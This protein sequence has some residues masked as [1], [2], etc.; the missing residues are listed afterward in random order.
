[1]FLVS[2]I[3]WLMLFNW[4]FII[5]HLSNKA[6]VCCLYNLWIMIVPLYTLGIFMS[7][8]ALHNP[9]DLLFSHAM[10]FSAFTLFFFHLSLQL[11]TAES[12]EKWTQEKKKSNLWSMRRKKSQ[13]SSHYNKSFF[14]E[15]D[16][17]A[18]IAV[19]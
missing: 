5:Y 4:T 10:D 9:F 6:I 1:M 17:V 16:A 2:W 8:Y 13:Y 15:L 14:M 18:P 7:N 12:N 3:V 11:Q 19:S